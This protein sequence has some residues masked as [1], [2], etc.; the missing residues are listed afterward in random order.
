MK[1]NAEFKFFS[2]WLKS[3]L[4]VASVTP[5]SA[6]L[7]R[8]M[9]SGL[10][11]HEGLVIELGAGTGPITYAL[12]QAGVSAGELVVIERDSHFCRHLTQRF[13]GIT[14]LRGD[15]L[16]MVSLVEALSTG[17]P[18]RAVVSSLPLLSMNAE[19]Q[20]RLLQQA[21]Q[22]TRGKG[23]LIQFS[24]RLTSPLRKSVESELGL[25]PR[26]VAQVWRNVPPAKVWTFES[27]VTGS[28]YLEQRVE[29]PAS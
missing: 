5:S 3:P 7:A 14:V 17:R 27:A 20:K 19:V 25:V 15:A 1:N 26:C 28:P 2:K 8:V 12:L 24:Y 11:Q 10:P 16:Q 29:A 9:A 22:L 13:P 18:V 23:P 6:R 21:M 4:H